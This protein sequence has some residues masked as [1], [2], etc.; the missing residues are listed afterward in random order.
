MSDPHP[1]VRTALA[2]LEQ[3]LTTS[4]PRAEERPLRPLPDDWKDDP[5][6]VLIAMV[7]A[8][9]DRDGVA[10]ALAWF[11]GRG[12]PDPQAAPGAGVMDVGA[13][14]LE[15]LQRAVA[16]DGI[17]TVRRRFGGAFGGSDDDRG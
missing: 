4:A 3:V 2:E 14:V 5:V 13:V 1:T 16:S 11:Y 15:V 17:D 6:K 12:L 10:R 8:Q 9:P 7:L